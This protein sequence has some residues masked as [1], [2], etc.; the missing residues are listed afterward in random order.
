MVGQQAFESHRTLS[1]WAH[2]FEIGHVLS[3]ADAD[4]AE[5]V[6]LIDEDEA[7]VTVENEVAVVVGAVASDKVDA[8]TGKHCA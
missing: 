6:E 4:G 2:A 8:V 7:R 3:E 1:H 5:E